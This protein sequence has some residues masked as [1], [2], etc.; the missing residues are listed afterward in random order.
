MS[1]ADSADRF[2]RRALHRHHGRQLRHLAVHRDVIG[3]PEVAHEI[4]HHASCDRR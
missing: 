4:L 3:W 2:P 1:S